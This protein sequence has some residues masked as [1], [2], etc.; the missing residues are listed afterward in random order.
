MRA[1]LGILNSK[2]L[3]KSDTRTRYIKR[4]RYRKWSL[5]NYVSDTTYIPSRP[6]TLRA[7]VSL[8]ILF[9]YLN[10]YLPLV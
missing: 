2:I 7:L 1:I 10:P 3:G 9:I 6:C 5:L 4:S 8:F